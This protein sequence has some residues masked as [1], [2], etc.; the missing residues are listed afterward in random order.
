MTIYD[1]EP[2]REFAKGEGLE[3]DDDTVDVA[4]MDFALAGLS[5]EQAEHMFRMYVRW[6]QHYSDPGLYT[7]RQRIAIAL[8]FLLGKRRA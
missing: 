6:T 2:M 7:W 4:D 1:W 8:H 3:F 5:Q